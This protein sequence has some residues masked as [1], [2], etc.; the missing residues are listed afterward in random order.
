MAANGSILEPRATPRMPWRAGSEWPSA[1]PDASAC[2]RQ[3]T[4]QIEPPLEASPWNYSARAYAVPLVP[5][6]VFDFVVAGWMPHRDSSW[7]P[8]LTEQVN[9]VIAIENRTPFPVGSV[10]V[11][12]SSRRS[13]PTGDNSRAGSY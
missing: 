9:C 10:S 7:I 5:H 6:E 4:A 3:P 1:P 2:H 12:D 8:Q 11:G 13:Q